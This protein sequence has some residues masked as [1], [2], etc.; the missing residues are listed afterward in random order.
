MKCPDHMANMAAMPGS[1]FC[2]KVCY[3]MLLVPCQ[4]LP[5]KNYITPAE[6]GE[7]LYGTAS[8]LPEVYRCN[9]QVSNR[10]TYYIVESWIF[11]SELFS[12]HHVCLPISTP[13]AGILTHIHVLL[14]GTGL[15]I[16]SCKRQLSRF[17][18]KPSIC[19]CKTI[20]ADQLCSNCEADQRFYFRYT[21]STIPF[22]PISRISSF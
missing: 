18:K 8:T 17:M 20:G 1:C 4:P 15:Y 2:V 9:F 12:S 14:S 6:I 19:L 21:D 7:N 10:F 3:D 13:T 11:H 16:K 22:L 5:V